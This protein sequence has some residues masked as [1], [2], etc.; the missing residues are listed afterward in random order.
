MLVKTPRVLLYQ[1]VY[2]LGDLKIATE[3]LFKFH[4]LQ[5][6]L[7]I[8][9][10]VIHYLWEMIAVLI[11]SHILKFKI[12]QHKLSTK[13]QQVKSVKIKFFIVIKEVLTQKRL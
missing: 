3:V 4:H 1:K 12:K 9:L 11:P 2:L 6:M 10:N 8:S 7:E 13:Q 5:K